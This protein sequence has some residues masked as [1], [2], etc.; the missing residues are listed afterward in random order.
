MYT[1]T[2]QN[3]LS[4]WY[5]F[6][7]ISICLHTGVIIFK[8]AEAMILKGEAGKESGRKERQEEMM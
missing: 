5:L 8:E 7:Y 4:M 2:A 6:I 1:C 3:E